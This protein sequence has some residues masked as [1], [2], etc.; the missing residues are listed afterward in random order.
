MVLFHH[1]WKMWKKYSSIENTTWQRHWNELIEIA[2]VWSNNFNKL[3]SIIIF[4]FFFDRKLIKIWLSEAYWQ[5]NKII[6]FIVKRD[7]IYIEVIFT[8]RQINIVFLVSCKAYIFTILWINLL[9]SVTCDIINEYLNSNNS[10][11]TTGFSFK[12]WDNRI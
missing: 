5:K 9:H 2:I 1:S 10:S 6:I 12:F 7:S 4:H 8:N 3:R 11:E